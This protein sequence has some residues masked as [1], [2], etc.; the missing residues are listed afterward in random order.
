MS[1]D[2]SSEIVYLQN[3]GSDFH[4]KSLP[5]RTKASKNVVNCLNRAEATFEA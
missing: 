3:A 5:L 2:F 1:C 4:Q